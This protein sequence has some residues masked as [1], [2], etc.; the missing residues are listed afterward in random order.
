MGFPTHSI[1]GRNGGKVLVSGDGAVT[2]AFYCIQV[3]E[4]A[5]LHADT[6][7][8]ITDLAGKTIPLGV[9]VFGRFTT[10]RVTSGTVVAYYA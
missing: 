5:V 4:E 2:G 1:D 3:L 8:S 6:A 7:V 10:I 9:S